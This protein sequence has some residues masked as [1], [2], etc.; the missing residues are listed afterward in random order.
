MSARGGILP[1]DYGRPGKDLVVAVT[2]TDETLN[3]AGYVSPDFMNGILN[4]MKSDTALPVNSQGE[5]R[6]E[7][8]V[9]AAAN[10]KAQPLAELPAL[11]TQIS[12]KT[13]RLESPDLLLREADVNCLP[14]EDWQMA[15]LALDFEQDQAT[16]KLQAL[17]G[18]EL[19]IPV[20]LDGIY[21]ITTS[22]LGTL[23]ARGQWVNDAR[24][25]FDVRRLDQGPV[26]AYD[27][28]FSNSEFTGTVT[29]ARS[30]DWYFLFPIQ[31]VL[32][33][34]IVN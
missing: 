31:S 13:F 14:A 30:G 8:A 17:S 12:G 24:F 18:A 11:A 33:G 3:E 28:I 22:P 1:A 32:R 23:A 26:L 29:S 4:T 2:G 19:N 16:L 25:Q 34:E 7:A 27:L 10:P 15:T 21:R 5:A 9:Q 20:G 6:L